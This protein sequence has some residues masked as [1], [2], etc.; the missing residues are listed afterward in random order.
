MSPASS[1]ITPRPRGFSWGETPTSGR[2]VEV[3]FIKA[4]DPIIEVVEQRHYGHNQGADPVEL[5][6][7]YAGVQGQPITVK[8]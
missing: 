2:Y 6:V 3:A 7:F 1:L 5:I 8:S 4:G